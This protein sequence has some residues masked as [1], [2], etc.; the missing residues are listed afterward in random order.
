MQ[1]RQGHEVNGT[2]KHLGQLVRELLD[3]PT[4]HTSREQLV[5]DV[6]ITVSGRASASDGSE[7][8]EA[9]YAVAFADGS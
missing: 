2:T 6:D 5:Q 3:L 7:D 9:P 8:Q 4:Q 1:R